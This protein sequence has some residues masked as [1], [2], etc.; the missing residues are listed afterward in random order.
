M[1]PLETSKYVNNILSNGVSTGV[2]RLPVGRLEQGARLSVRG[3]GG[4]GQD[5]EEKLERK[6][7]YDAPHYKLSF[8]DRLAPVDRQD[9]DMLNEY[10]ELLHIDTTP[11]DYVQYAIHN[12]ELMLDYAIIKIMGDRAKFL[13]AMQLFQYTDLPHDV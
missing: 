1:R 7:L 3:G 10:L 6:W 13:S 8:K 11:K 12:I 2:G 4:L 9:K 5:E